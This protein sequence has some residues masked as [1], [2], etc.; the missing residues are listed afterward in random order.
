MRIFC[1]IVLITALAAIAMPASSAD[2]GAETV[3]VV[4]AQRPA[5]EVGDFPRQ[6]IRITVYTSPGGLI[7]FTARRFAEIARKYAPEQPFVVINRPGGGGIVAFEEVLQQPADGYH[8]LAVTRS[9]V[10]KLIATG[11]DDLIERIDWHSYIMDNAHVVITNAQRGA[12]SWQEVYDDALRSGDRQLW[13]GADIGG[14]KHVSGVKMARQAGMQMRW[15]PYGSGGEAIAALLGNLGAVY[16]GNPRDA[17]L[18]E[19]L[20][21]VAV[22]APRRL[23]AFPDAPTFTELGVPGLEDEHIWRGFAFRKGV[24]EDRR[25]WFA[26]LIEKVTYDPEWI[27]SW[28]REGVS[29]EYRDS[30]RF[31]RL[32]QR[33]VEEFSFYLREMGL[34]REPG[35]RETLLAGIGEGPALRFLQVLLVFVNIVLA[36]VLLQ[37][38]F[39]DRIGELMVLSVVVSLA[40]VFY[41]MTSA[42]PPPSPV[43]TVGVGGVP[44]LWM[45]LL[46][47]LALY[48]SYLILRDR[49]KGKPKKKPLLMFTFLGFLTSYVLLIPILGY[50][51]ASLIY[52]PGVL[53]LLKY[54]QPVAISVLTL[55]WLAF[56]YVV[57]Q[58]TLYVDL[59]AGMLLRQ[60]NL[61]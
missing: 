39:R 9:N 18:S 25:A 12:G 40:L 48:Q 13:L 28:A 6:P 49:R 57:F 35:S 61:A 52:M 3:A 47:P 31:T 54:R 51:L 29:L 22:A 50:M 24:P 56:S 37:T 20:R 7:D 30:E 4:V 34:L 21:I 5:P 58:R 14:V 55:S 26:D 44:R 10:S 46:L 36:L 17:M 23:E 38:S 15:I 43:D 41:A 60:L 16:L 2:G 42:L 59:P 27:D 33:D 11:R 45:F 1:L 32:V 19:D 53:W 8:M